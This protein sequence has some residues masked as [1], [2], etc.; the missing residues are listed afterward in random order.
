MLEDEKVGR[1]HFLSLCAGLS[2]DN[3]LAQWFDLF[4]TPDERHIMVHRYLIVKALLKGGKTQRE[5]AKYLK[6]SIA[7]ITRASNALKE[8]DET[9]KELLT[10]EMIDT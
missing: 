5:I 3:E 8:T 4:F 9:F 2:S 10:K 7:K 1:E 6:V